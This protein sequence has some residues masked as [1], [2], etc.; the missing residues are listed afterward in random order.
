MDSIWYVIIFGYAFAFI[1]LAVFGIMGSFEAIDY[2]NKIARQ[3]KLTESFILNHK[4]S[5]E[6]K[7]VNPELLEEID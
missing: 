3:K 5:H 4:Y 7:S 1:L 6:L 2:Q